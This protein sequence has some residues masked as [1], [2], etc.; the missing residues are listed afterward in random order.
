MTGLRG[1][2]PLL[3]LYAGRA[4]TAIV[5]LL[6]LPLLHDV[7]GTATFGAVGIVLALQ[8][9]VVM[10][11]FG[12]AVSSGRAAASLSAGDTWHLR[13]LVRHIDRVIVVVYGCLGTVAV[14]A[15]PL[16]GL[17]PAPMAALFLGLAAIT[18]QNASLNILI[19]R[20][21]YRLASASQFGGILLR[22][23]IALGSLHLFSPTLDVFIYAQAG[24]AVVHA[25]ASR[26]G[27]LLLA[28]EN[29]VGGDRPHDRISPALAIVGIAG[30]CALQV[31]KPLIGLLADPA[32][33]APYYLASVLALVPI[34]FLAGPVAQFF[35]PT[36]MLAL[37]ERRRQDMVQALS[38]LAVVLC[39][40]TVGPGTVLLVAAEPITRLWLGPEPLQP[41]VA[42]YLQILIVGGVIG[43]I[44]LI[45]SMLL[46]ASKDYRFLAFSSVTLT[47]FLLGAV[48]IGAA[49]H[50]IMSVCYA[51]AAYHV[52]ATV[53][54]WVRASGLHPELNRAVVAIPREIGTAFHRIR[55]REV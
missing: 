12:L 13:P 8:A 38:R 9:L 28:G 43:S 32:S 53:V 3:L 46:I 29:R 41:L 52:A 19:G 24:V 34:S 48:A 21:A 47:T 31:D 40:A 25:L 39:I 2:I 44:G 33:A 45:P 54:L 23:S 1:L 27:A 55:A 5:G 26:M 4:G 37:A 20:R 30:A 51:Y 50:D 17:G 49:A 22:H 42:S 11:D 15:S 36:V 35:Q 18:H 7:L 6:V 16:V 14:L 10:L